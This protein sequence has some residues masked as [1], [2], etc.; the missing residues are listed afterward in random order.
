MLFCKYYILT[1]LFINWE[2][3]YQKCLI[4]PEIT[5]YLWLIHATNPTD[6]DSMDVTKSNC[7]DQSW[8]KPKKKKYEEF[9]LKK[10]ESILIKYVISKKIPRLVLYPQQSE[11][12]FHLFSRGSCW[13]NRILT[14]QVNQHSS[15]VFLD[16][17]THELLT[18]RSTCDRCQH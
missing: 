6:S 1:W 11:T 16:T 15:P 12:G 17:G 7:D 14:P 2:N 8:I 10:T 3:P 18:A 9:L 13:P 4:V 5:W